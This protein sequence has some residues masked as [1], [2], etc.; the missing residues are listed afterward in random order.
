MNKDPVTVNRINWLQAMPSLR[1]FGAFGLGFR[2]RCVVSACIALFFIFLATPLLLPENWQSH[3]PPSDEFYATE[4]EEPVPSL[5]ATGD[6]L[7]GRLNA[8]SDDETHEEYEF[9][10]IPE[11]DYLDAFPLPVSFVAAGQGQILTGRGA[12]WKN[13]LL[14]SFGVLLLLIF[15]TAICRSAALQFC[16]GR[17]S[18]AFASLRF[19]VGQLPRTLLSTG[20]AALIV[21]AP[22]LLISLLGWL[23]R[24]GL[25]AALLALMWP[26]LMAAS[27]LAFA[28]SLVVGVGWMLSL[29]A[30]ATDE[31]S[32]SDALSRGINYVLSHKARTL[33]YLVVTSALSTIAYWLATGILDAADAI[34]R[35][36]FVVFLDA[37]RNGGTADGVAVTA[38]SVWNDVLD[39]LPRAVE[40]SVFMAGITLMYVLLRYFEDA[41]ELR[42]TNGGQQAKKL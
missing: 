42:E 10:V 6:L 30:V 4:R 2:V 37:S 25:P 9:S 8:F 31:C 13:L 32:G 21:A 3:Y 26:L 24:F 11:V 33:G 27:V 22:L 39:C 20:L 41:V 14:E 29:S 38:L 16:Q 35:V 5:D 34:L 28:T 15:G 17:R 19:A 7:A 23:A 36:R 1:L 40:F 18:G 12:G